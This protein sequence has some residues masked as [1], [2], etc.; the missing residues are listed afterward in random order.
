MLLVQLNQ[1]HLTCVKTHF[2][3]LDIDPHLAHNPAALPDGSYSLHN[4]DWGST[5]N[6]GVW[7]V[8]PRSLFPFMPEL[9]KHFAE[10]AKNK[11]KEREYK[12]LPAAEVDELSAKI[13]HQLP[14]VPHLTKHKTTCDLEQ[15]CTVLSKTTIGGTK[16]KASNI[17]RHIKKYMSNFTVDV[18][19]RL[20]Q[21]LLDGTEHAK[22]G[23][24]KEQQKTFASEHN[25]A[26][27]DS[28]DSA[29]LDQENIH[30]FAQQRSALGDTFC[31]TKTPPNAAKITLLQISRPRNPGNTKIGRAHV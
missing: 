4:G 23:L 30:Q 12:L 22:R 31:D 26:L 25:A 14:Q 28:A 1:I 16:I 7:T 10:Q 2:C 24:V 9:A 17:K 11:A 8:A 5:T 6:D 27:A 18:Q 21:M 29:K 13:S 3:F 15:L 19:D 20:K